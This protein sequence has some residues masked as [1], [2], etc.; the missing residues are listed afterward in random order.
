MVL[1]GVDPESQRLILEL[2]RQDGD[3]VES[4]IHASSVHL[5]NVEVERDRRAPEQH[6][7]MPGSSF[8]SGSLNT[9][10]AYPGQKRNLEVEEDYPR[11]EKRQATSREAN[12]PNIWRMRLEDIRQRAAE[13]AAAAGGN[14]SNGEETRHLDERNHSLDIAND[15]G[16]ENEEVS[17]LT[18][19]AVL[20]SI[21]HDTDKFTTTEN[22]RQT[23]HVSRRPDFTV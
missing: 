16:V 12:D 4:A 17:P 6:L 11:P 9:E 21:D 13:A 14:V 18:H 15:N 5:R 23:S 10:R 1:E 7:S 22:V 8:S 19:S 20:S 2:M 3:D